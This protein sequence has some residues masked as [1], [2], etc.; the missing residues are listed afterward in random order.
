MRRRL[1]NAVELISPPDGRGGGL[2]LGYTFD[3]DTGGKPVMLSE[4]A[5]RDGTT[6]TVGVQSVTVMDDEIQN[7]K[8]LIEAY[9]TVKTDRA[10]NQS[11]RAA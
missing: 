2:F 6:L 4:N 10:R 5:D 7:L 1:A 3:R 11:R 8:A 9:E